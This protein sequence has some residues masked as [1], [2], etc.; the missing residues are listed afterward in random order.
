MKLMPG[1]LVEATQQLS[2]EDYD[3]VRNALESAGFQI[4]S[5]NSSGLIQFILPNNHVYRIELE[6]RP[7]ERIPSEYD[8]EIPNE[9]YG[10]KPRGHAEQK[11]K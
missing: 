4:V 6:R 2:S 7:N 1:T 5:S 9:Y 11:K 10:T 8:G 3:M